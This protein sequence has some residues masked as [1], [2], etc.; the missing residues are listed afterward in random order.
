MRAT[1]STTRDR[2]GR[3]PEAT[4]PRVPRT[5]AWRFARVIEM[6]KI[7]DIKLWIR[8]LFIIFLFLV[9]LIWECTDL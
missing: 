7:P 3:Q 2:S 8:F 1:A 9:F 6:G 4:S 5:D